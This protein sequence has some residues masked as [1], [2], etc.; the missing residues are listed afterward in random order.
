MSK[1][2]PFRTGRAAMES[3]ALNPEKDFISPAFSAVINKYAL[4]FPL[5]RRLRPD[6]KIPAR[7][8]IGAIITGLSIKSALSAAA[9][10]FRDVFVVRVKARSSFVFFYCVSRPVF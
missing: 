6:V 3:G 10:L 9:S 7:R 8:G 4:D 2:P 1:P 5:Q